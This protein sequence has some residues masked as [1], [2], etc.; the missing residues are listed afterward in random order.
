MESSHSFSFYKRT[1]KVD[2]ANSHMLVDG[3]NVP[4][5]SMEL[6]SATF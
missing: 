1:W 5:M 3:A 6:F 4:P 2:G